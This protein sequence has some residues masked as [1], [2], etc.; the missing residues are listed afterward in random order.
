[1]EAACNRVAFTNNGTYKV[2]VE[3]T[4]GAVRL[5]DSD[6]SNYVAVKAP[7]AV[8][9]DVTWTLPSADGTSGQALV[10][11]GSGTLS[12]TT[13]SFESSFG[14]STKVVTSN[15]TV[16]TTSGYNQVAFYTLDVDAGVTFTVSAG[17]VFTVYS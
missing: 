15:T 6:A 4:D 2:S 3:K 17:E 14:Q 12:F 8:T 1:M 7:T 11:N 10:T 5:Y 13:V 9:S 16:P